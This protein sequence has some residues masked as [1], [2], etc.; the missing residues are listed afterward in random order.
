MPIWV[1]ISN[2]LFSYWTDE[3]I[4]YLAS[5]IGKPL[6]ADE[7]TLKLDHIPFAKVCVEVNADFT[8]P[9]SLNVVVFDNTPNEDRFVTV[10]VEYQSRPPSCPSYKVF[11]HSH[12]RCPKAN[13]QWVPRARVNSKAPTITSETPQLSTIVKNSSNSLADANP[14]IGS[15]TTLI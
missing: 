2:I 15:L 6:F 4:S 8:F 14:T 12:I 5:G 13:Y 9:S 10:L 3:G 7:M 11:G 1:K